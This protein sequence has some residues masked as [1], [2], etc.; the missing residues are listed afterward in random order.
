MSKEKILKIITITCFV[1][2]GVLITVLII[3]SVNR[4]IK[5]NNKADEILEEYSDVQPD[6]P[7]EE[8]LPESDLIT[9]P[10]DEYVESVN[11]NPEEPDQGVTKKVIIDGKEYE[12]F[13]GGE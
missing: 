8:P 4:H 2:V 1:I 12:V 7:T 5:L 6:V 9:V 3:Y 10:Y 11:I 13:V